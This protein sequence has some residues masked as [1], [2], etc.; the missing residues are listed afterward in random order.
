MSALILA[1]QSWGRKRLFER[2]FIEFDI[3]CSEVDESV[4][5]PLDPAHL[6]E[7]LA[8]LKAREVAKFHPGAWVCGFDTVVSCEGQILGKP[9]D[10]DEARRI[11]KFLS[12]KNQS[13]FSGYCV[14][15]E[16]EGFEAS[17]YTETVLH[18]AKLSDD[19]I[20]D[21]IH[22][23]PVTRFAG[24]YGVQDN[25]TLVSILSGDMDTIVG[26]SM[27]EVRKI[28]R[29]NGLPSSYFSNQTAVE[30]ENL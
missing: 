2:D 14:V 13:V 6:T 23:N 1:S 20:E 10:L 9:A 4:I 17:G 15:R 3:H 21:Y 30:I 27:T 12:G 8:I 19:W 25:D 16:S 5:P 11:L 7:Q 28:L 29:H 24:G 22:H 18:F 26:A